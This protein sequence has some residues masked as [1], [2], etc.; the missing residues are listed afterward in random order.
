MKSIFLVLTF[1]VAS[2]TPT[3]A[4]ETAVEAVSCSYWI[5]VDDHCGGTFYLC[6]DHY[7]GHGNFRIIAD[8][9]YFSH[10]RCN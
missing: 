1:L 8:I 5:S 2:F 9:D 10:I 6:D 7:Q 3:S 4:I